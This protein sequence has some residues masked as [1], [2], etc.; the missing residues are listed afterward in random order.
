[1]TSQA[2]IEAC[3][4]NSL[5]STGPKTP[6]GLSK[7]SMNALKHGMRSKKQAL[8]LEDSYAFENRLH[9]WMA[10]ADPDDD[11]GEFLVHRYVSLSFEVERVK[12]HISKGSPA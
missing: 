12:L 6:E 2:K 10:S 1:M 7:S 5:K 3:R 8:L 4:R 9:K 11:M